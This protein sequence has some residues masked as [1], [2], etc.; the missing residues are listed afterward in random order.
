M[1]SRNPFKTSTTHY[2]QTTWL[3]TNLHRS[4]TG[5]LRI[6]NL[7]DPDRSELHVSPNSNSKA[8]AKEVVEEEAAMVTTRKT[9][10]NNKTNNVP[11]Y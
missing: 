11:P 2:T 8:Q 6:E 7:T 5:Y 1:G 9:S 4:E 3:M 10:E